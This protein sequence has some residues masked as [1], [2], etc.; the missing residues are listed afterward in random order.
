MALPITSTRP[1]QKWHFS[2]MN[3]NPAWQMHL[4]TARILPVRSV[5]VVAAIPKLSTYCAGWSAVT[6]G[7]KY[8]LMKPEKADTDLLRPCA[9]L[10]KAK[11]LRAKLNTSFS[12]DFWSA[13]CK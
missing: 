13:I 3:F 2:F 11:V 7:S 10:S 8:S 5:S 12:T 9:S 6:T 4:K 1:T